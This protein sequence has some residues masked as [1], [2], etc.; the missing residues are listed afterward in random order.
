MASPTTSSLPGSAS[1]SAP[2][3]SPLLVAWERRGDEARLIVVREG[4][5]D[6]LPL[7]GVPN[8]PVAAGLPGPLAFLSG[9]P[10]KPVMW[11]GRGPLAEPQWD[12][13][14]LVPPESQDESF[15]WL[16]IGS[17][18]PP[19]I[20][21]QSGDNRVYVI[22]DDRSLR[23][24]PASLLMLRPGGCA[25]SDRRRVVVATDA[26][27]PTF[28]IGFAMFDV[29]G[30]TASLVPGGGGE[31]PAVSDLSLAYVARDQAGRQAVWIGPIPGPGGPLPPP[32][33]R[34]AADGPD[35]GDLDF[36]RPVLS[37]DGRRLAV[38]ELA[39]PAAPRRLLVYDLSGAPTVVVELD[40]RGA[41][42][43]GPVWIANAP[44]D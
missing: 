32:I 9:S 11:T 19:R 40:V 34:I 21:V 26:S 18:S 2:A 36:F 28:H 5:I 22:E 31:A 13:V 17:E 20:A 12:A 8:G 35:S 37:A 15:A 23:L 25:W 43:A 1:P 44:A 4:S 42:D 14:R 7:P 27:Q 3:E 24:L 6:R 10:D 29:D 41:S 30:A 38:V 33:V 16:C 39:R